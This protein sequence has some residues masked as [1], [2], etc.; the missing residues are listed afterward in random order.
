LLELAIEAAVGVIAIGGG[1]NELSADGAR[2]QSDLLAGPMRPNTSGPD[3]P[4]VSSS[5]SP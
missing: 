3:S 4:G 5:S 1:F 2:S